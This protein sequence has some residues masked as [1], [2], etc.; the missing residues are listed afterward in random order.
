MPKADLSAALDGSLKPID[1]TD[2]NP[3]WA[4]TAG[5][6]ISTADELATYVDALVDGGLLDAE[7]QKTRMDSIQPIAPGAPVSYGLG[8]AQFAPNLFGHDGQLPG[9]SSFMAR[10]SED[11]NTII[12]F[13]NLSASPVDGENAAVVLGKTVIAALY[14]AS[15]V[16]G[17]D[18]AG[19][20]TGAT[21]SG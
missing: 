19:A 4:W 17:G 9:F 20:P 10:D 18:P 8:I 11:Q 13:A 7:M 12:I 2:A 3:S 5:G 16:P 21:P 14:G 1:Y 6:A 15:A